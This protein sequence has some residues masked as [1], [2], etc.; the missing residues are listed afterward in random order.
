MTAAL[1]LSVCGPLAVVGSADTS[2]KLSL[3]N[4]ITGEDVPL[5]LYVHTTNTTSADELFPSNLPP[6]RPMLHN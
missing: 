1:S 3:L 2:G 5:E 4:R 6:P